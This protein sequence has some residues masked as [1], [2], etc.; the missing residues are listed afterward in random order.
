[1]INLSR[2]CSCP[3]LTKNS[4]T[5][6]GVCQS[7][8]LKVSLAILAIAIP[9]ILMVVGGLG[10]AGSA[11]SGLLIFGGISLA[12][13]GL[14]VATS[15]IRSRQSVPV[16]E[17][18]GFIPREEEEREPQPCPELTAEGRVAL[19]NAMEKFDE[20]RDTLPLSD[21][22]GLRDPVNPD[23]SRLLTLKD[24]KNNEV[25]ELL[26]VDRNGRL[27]FPDDEASRDPVLVNAVTELMELS[28]AVSMY[29]L[30]DLEAYREK[31]PEVTSNLEA[32]SRQE[33]A[34]YKTFYQMSLSYSLLRHLHMYSQNDVSAADIASRRDRF[35]QEGT[36]EFRWRSLYNC[37]CQQARWYIGNEQAA[38]QRENRLI[39]H[40]TPDTSCDDFR[41][42][43]TIPT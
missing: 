11:S 19:N 24:R 41:Y 40:S 16:S 13:L 33:S 3:N 17:E 25:L 34:Y 43:G 31:F 1:M 38:V 18:V 35:Y 9:I 26:H 42:P 2:L 5:S 29:S 4:E 12:V 28:F 32:L 21:W 10:L 20:E 36:P 39:R 15:C 30:R 14:V 27:A 22:G 8:S 23:I 6:Q 37:F 7:K